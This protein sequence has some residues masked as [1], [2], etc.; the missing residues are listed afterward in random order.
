LSDYLKFF[1]S[2]SLF[3]K[4]TIMSIKHISLFT[5]DICSSLN[6]L[7]ILGMELE[8]SSLLFRCCAIADPGHGSR[9]LLLR[10]RRRHRRRSAANGTSGHAFFFFFFFF[11]FFLLS[12]GA[13]GRDSPMI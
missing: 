9:V 5:T 13:Q 3:K 7:Q 10:R 4:T 2:T 8:S 6:R 12:R 11:F 1:W